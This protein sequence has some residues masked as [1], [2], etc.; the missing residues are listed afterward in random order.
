MVTERILLPT[1]K[2]R[3]D[4]NQ[5]SDCLWIFTQNEIDLTVN[6]LTFQALKKKRNYC[7]WWKTKRPNIHIDDLIEVYLFFIKK[8]TEE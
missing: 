5:T 8:K 1:K 3:C 2:N 7:I 6:M 4:N